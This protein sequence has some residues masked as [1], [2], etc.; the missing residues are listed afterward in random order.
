MG[1]RLDAAAS[2]DTV[3]ALSRLT[4]RVEPVLV[5]A[6]VS[7]AALAPA[8][9]AG[10]DARPLALLLHGGG[11]TATGP[12]VMATMNQ[13]AY[14]YRR[15]GF[16][17]RQV[18]YGPGGEQSLRDAIAAYDRI[19]RR[20]SGP[21]VAVGASAGGQVALMLSRR[22]GLAAVVVYAAPT[23]LTRPGELLAPGVRAAFRS[24]HMRE[25]SPGIRGFGHTAV[26][27]VYSAD[28]PLVPPSQ[29]L[30]LRRFGAEIRIV[31]PGP[32]KLYFMHTCVDAAAW[33]LTAAAERRFLDRTLAPRQPST[34]AFL[35][36]KGYRGSRC[37]TLARS[38]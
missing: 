14:R 8:P 23:D 34:V 1:G 32:V 17:V 26:F 15:R 35:I 36:R 2:A 24:D 11:W 25:Y 19:R 30:L 9:A 12:H 7:A 5:A 38:S 18:D 37:R 10:V 21:I 22:R 31:P 28:D 4:S 29:G 3:R 27:G 16:R 13:L 33:R 20:T 6:V